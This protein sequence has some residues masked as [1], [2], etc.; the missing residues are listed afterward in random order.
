MLSR[1]IF[2]KFCDEESY[3]YMFY[4]LGYDEKYKMNL[5]KN[6]KFI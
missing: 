3:R 6:I 5:F 2:K 4:N 1:L